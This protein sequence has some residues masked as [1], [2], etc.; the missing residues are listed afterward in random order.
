[1]RSKNAQMVAQFRHHFNLPVRSFPEPD[2][3]N[4]ELHARL[5]AEEVG[6]TLSAIRDGD[7]VELLDGLTDLIVVAYGCAL[8]CGFDLDAAFEEVHRSNMSKLGEDGKPILR[9]DGK[10][11]KGPNYSPPDL[12]ALAGVMRG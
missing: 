3:A 10:I 2:K 1:M 9:D 5:L 6:E 11:L 7:H 12:R 8:D 4:L